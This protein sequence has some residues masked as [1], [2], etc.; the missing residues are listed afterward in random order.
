[1]AAGRPP[2]G[3]RRPSLRSR[4]AQYVYLAFGERSREAATELSMTEGGSPL[5]NAA[6][7][8]DA[9]ARVRRSLVVADAHRPVGRPRITALPRN[10]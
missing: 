4:L 3:R 2:R 6:A 9:Q 8:R 1:M 5:G 10:R 7:V